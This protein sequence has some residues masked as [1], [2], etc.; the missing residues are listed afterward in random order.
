MFP[1]LVHATVQPQQW[2]FRHAFVGQTRGL[3]RACGLVGYPNVGK[4]SLF[5][6]FAGAAVA[7]AENFP[8]CTIEPNIVKVGV[9]DSRLDS[10]A[11]LFSSQRTVPGQVEIRDI[12]GLIK[13]ASTGAGMGNA[14][15]SQI[16]G[17]Q[18][19]FHVVRC[20]SDQKVVHVEDPINID[21]V[22]EYESILEEL[23]IADLEYASKRLP[24]LRKKATTAPSTG[25]D[26]AKM[27]AI[28]EEILK[29]LEDGKPARYAL[30]RQ[31]EDCLSPSDDFLAQLITA[32]PVVVLANVAAEDA[33]SGNEFTARLAEHVQ[34]DA[35]ALG[36]LASRFIIV[37]AQL[38]AEVAALDD[39]DFQAEY[40]ES[41]GLDTNSPRALSRVLAE[42][43]S[44]L[45]LISFL[46]VGE[47]EARAWFVPLG[48]RAHEAAGAIHSDFT[49]NFEQAEIWSYDDLV[50]HGSKEKCRKAGV[51]RLQGKDYKVQDGDVIEFRIKKARS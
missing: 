43:Q 23:V 6:A 11:E 8:F 47:M 38:E 49:K 25:S 9:P 32:K 1:R 46:T 7:A 24:A 50:K 17:V 40:L 16:R 19:V 30:A 34:T 27:L 48:S 35:Q 39:K 21:P 51:A 10:L 36:G 26:P 42:S 41:F 28:Y 13:G 44:L 37:S 45:K 18:V 5:N 20:F 15:L 22:K 33:A 29:C 4:S 31:D 12:A 14:F 2:F 3:N